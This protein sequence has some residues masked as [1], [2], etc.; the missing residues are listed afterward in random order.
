LRSDPKDRV[1]KPYRFREHWF[2]HAAA[3]LL[4]RRFQKHEFII[5]V[6]GDWMAEISIR[7][8]GITY[9]GVDGKVTEAVRDVDLQIPSGEPV[10]LIGPSGCGKSS[11]LEMIAGLRKRTAGVIEVDGIPMDR[12][13]RG[14]GYIPQGGGLLPWLNALDNAA[15]ALT[16]NG[17]P[18]S[19][20]QAAAREALQTVGLAEYEKA[21]PGEL[22]GGMRQRLALAR[23]LASGCDILL[24]DEPFSALD[25]ITREQ[26]QDVLLNLWQRTGYTQIL[27]THSV[28]E[29]VLLARTIV[30]MTPRPGRVRQV[31]DNPGMG[32][33]DYRDTP[34]FAALSKQIRTLL[35]KEMEAE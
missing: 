27:V 29:A 9:S 10:C 26:M 23:S 7:G 1:S 20:R 16:I 11:L 12:P 25:S 3:R 21:F 5:I 15:L 32:P 33:I 28:E 8:V 14:T 2:R 6:T 4:N 34:E 31:F 17:T 19:K 13:R 22:S 18:R 30:L 35:H 24:V